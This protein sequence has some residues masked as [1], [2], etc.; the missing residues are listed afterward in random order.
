MR[1]EFR[2]SVRYYA[3]VV[4][5]SGGFTLLL[6]YLLVLRPGSIE[7]GWLGRALVGAFLFVAL[8]ALIA[9]V[10]A[11]IRN[12]PVMIV[13]RDGVLLRVD[14]AG[15]TFAN[16]KA[17][18]NVHEALLPWS[19][20]GAMAFRDGVVV[21]IGGD[22]RARIAAAV[23]A[24]TRPAREQDVGVFLGHEWE[25]LD[26]RDLIGSIAERFAQEPDLHLVRI[27]GL[28]RPASEVYAALESSWHAWCGQYGVPV[29]MAHVQSGADQP[30][31]SRAALPREST[32]PPPL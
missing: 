20:V 23:V 18:G 7:M 29:P 3:F 25:P 11:W 32:A 19:M 6:A 12:E 8:F 21:S 5:F 2:F 9:S 10:R 14:V 27:S 13:Q 26:V 30:V 28:D 16:T 1:T 4:L 17:F 15:R 22:R 24:L 31:P